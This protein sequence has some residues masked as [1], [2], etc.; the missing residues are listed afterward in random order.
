MKVELVVFY[1]DIGDQ[2]FALAALTLDMEPLP[3]LNRNLCPEI[4]H[5][6]VVT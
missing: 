1:M 6:L 3:P 4:F 2:R 5:E